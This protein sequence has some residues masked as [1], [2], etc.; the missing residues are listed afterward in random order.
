MWRLVFYATA[1]RRVPVQEFLDSLSKTEKAKVFI[2]LDALE[3]FGLT[4]KAPY[5]RSIGKKLWELRTTGNSQ[6]R[7][8]YFAVAERRLVLL[9]GFTKKTQKT[10]AAEIEKALKRMADFQ[11]KG[12]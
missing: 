10:R 5:V 6:H 3:E 1:N 4:L 7:I 8:L 11:R 12:E 9:H 2:D